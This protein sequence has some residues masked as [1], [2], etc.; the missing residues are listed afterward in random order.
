M[1][2]GAVC[3]CSSVAVMFYFERFRGAATGVAAAGNGLGYIAIPFLL[4]FL[5]KYFGTDVAWRNA[6][7][8]YSIILIMVTFLGSLTFRPLEIETPTDKEMERIEQMVTASNSQ[9]GPKKDN[10]A[11][12][13]DQFKASPEKLEGNE[14]ST[15]NNLWGKLRPDKSDNRIYGVN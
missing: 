1:G 14:I 2:L 4:S 7:L 12:G 5:S 9:I 13:D 10:E 8:V 11:V 3:L 6:L 15:C